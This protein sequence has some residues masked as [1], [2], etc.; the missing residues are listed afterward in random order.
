MKNASVGGTWYENRYPGCACDIPAH[1]YTFPFE[2]NPEWS[3]F[4]ASVRRGVNLATLLCS[5][6]SYLGSGDSRELH[7]LLQKTPAGTV[8]C[9]HTEVVEAEWVD[10]EGLWH[11]TLK[12]TTDGSTFVDKANVIINGS[13][14]L[15]KWKW[16][17][18]PG[19]HDFKGELAGRCHRHWVQLHSNGA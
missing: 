12:N 14:V 4:Y 5:N 18:L 8:R 13:G 9:S 19:L 16:P 15:T 17:D 1:T 10:L 6:S 3:E 7:A 2:P 11:V